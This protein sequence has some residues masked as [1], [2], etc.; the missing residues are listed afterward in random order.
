MIEAV[1]LYCSNDKRFAEACVQSLLDCNIKTHVITYT[2]MWSGDEEDVDALNSSLA[3]HRDHKHFN[4]YQVSWNEGQSPWYWEG[5]G[6]YLGTQQISENCD[7]ILYIDIDEIVDPIKFNNWLSSGDYKNYDALKLACYW[8]WREPEYQAEVLEDS[9]VMLRASAARQLPMQP[10][11]RENY[12]NKYANSVRLVEEQD[13]MVHHY[14]WVRSKEE[15]LKKTNN[16]SHSKDRSD[17]HNLIEEEFSRPFNGQS[18]VNGYRF[19]NV[20]NHFNI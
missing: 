5:L 9:I 3:K 8:Y 12:F 17:W 13:P 16:W 4:H 1:V 18:F 6:R 14:S 19:K 20:K 15:M 2:H 11:G 10:G 7:Y